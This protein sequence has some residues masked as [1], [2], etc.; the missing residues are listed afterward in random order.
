[1]SLDYASIL[2]ERRYLWQQQEMQIKNDILSIDLKM[3]NLDPLTEEYRKLEQQKMELTQKLYSS[4]KL[5]SEKI[6]ELEEKVNEEKKKNKEALVSFARKFKAIDNMFSA[7]EKVKKVKERTQ[8]GLKIATKVV[9]G[10]AD[11]A[12]KSVLTKKVGGKGMFHIGGKR[13][14]RFQFDGLLKKYSKDFQKLSD[15][16]YI[17]G[18]KLF[19]KGF[20][21]GKAVDTTDQVQVYDLINYLKDKNKSEKDIFKALQ[22]FKDVQGDISQETLN[23][24]KSGF[25]TVKDRL[26]GE[27]DE[28]PLNYGSA[29]P[30]GTPSP[31]PPNQVTDQHLIH[32]SLDDEQ[33]EELFSDQKAKKQAEQIDKLNRKDLTETLQKFYNSALGLQRDAFKKE[34]KFSLTNVVTKFLPKLMKFFSFTGFVMKILTALTGIVLVFGPFVK[35]KFM[36]WW[37]GK[38]AEKMVEAINGQEGKVTSVLNIEKDAQGN[39]LSEQ[40]ILN[41]AGI[42]EETGK[43]PANI[44]SD[45]EK[46]V[47]FETTQSTLDVTKQQDAISSLDINE[48]I[49]E[50]KQ[51]LDSSIKSVDDSIENTEEQ[52]K[53][54]GGLNKGVEPK[55]PQTLLE[56]KSKEELERIKNPTKPEQVTSVLELDWDKQKT[57]EEQIQN[58]LTPDFKDNKQ[59][60]LNMKEPVSPKQKEVETKQKQQDSAP[61]QK[62][63]NQVAKQEIINKQEQIAKANE[64]RNKTLISKRET[65]QKTSATYDLNNVLGTAGLNITNIP[66]RG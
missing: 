20:N 37:N 56:E 32:V 12:L 65:K 3:R 63:I 42:S 45:L 5:T 9:K 38:K 6:I 24:V 66:A 41:I 23:V 22:M 55:D 60:I 64:E 43:E 35:K 40:T 47:T 26:A 4:S 25:S 17:K 14:G 18:Q 58:L 62:D 48:G 1:M 13:Q 29:L 59:G 39:P 2:S 36:E 52:K 11:F 8:K 61:I 51:D 50:V 34:Q 53:T 21:D 30:D 46:Q 31:F 28:N 49:K 10:T 57:Q 19:V 44:L 15:D 33:R 27:L 54:I 16:M 7:Y